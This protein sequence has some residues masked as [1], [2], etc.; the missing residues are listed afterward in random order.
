MSLKSKTNK[1]RLFKTVCCLWFITGL[2]AL[3]IDG[4][5]GQ[6]DFADRVS[7]VNMF[8]ITVMSGLVIL[9]YNCKKFEKWLNKPI[10]R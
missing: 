4:A 6:L 3:I 8:W 7:I 1:D 9:K 5:R 10:F 2:I